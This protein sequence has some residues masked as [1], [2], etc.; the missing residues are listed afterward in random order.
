MR[1]GILLFGLMAWSAALAWTALGQTDD[2]TILNKFKALES[3]IEKARKYFLAENY[4]KCEKEAA[5]CLEVLPDH[6]EAH[7]FMAQVLYK[8]GEFDKALEQML[9]AESGYLRLQ[10]VV[11]RV[12]QKKFE[13]QL[14][15]KVDLTEQLEDW[16]AALQ[17]TTCMKG[18]YQGIVLDKEG[19]L[20]AESKY[21][22]SELAKANSQVPAEYAYFH[23]NCLFRLKNYGE[24]E[25]HY[26]AAIRIDPRHANACNNLINLLYM[27][28]RLE[29]AR[30]LISQA[31]ANQ[32]AIVPGLKNAVL[33]TGGK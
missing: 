30:T 25:D 18:V 17:Q 21:S 11:D 6:H 14:D 23:G 9:S 4:A 12:Q 20:N 19:K 29:E 22:E 10:G 1:R 31:E 24:A 16:S 27:Q 3:R 28:K 5:G 2:A 26:R 32:V 7:F 33:S 13:K 8:R 15:K